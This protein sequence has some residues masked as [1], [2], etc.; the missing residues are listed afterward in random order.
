MN[1]G[2]INQGKLYPKSEL[3]RHN[4]FYESPYTEI[5]NSRPIE[6]Y[7]T[8]FEST[9]ENYGFII[10]NSFLPVFENTSKKYIPF[11][12]YFKAY[13]RKEKFIPQK[14][15]NAGII[16]LIV[17]LVLCIIYS[18]ATFFFYEIYVETGAPLFLVYIIVASLTY[19]PLANKIKSS[20]KLEN[21]ELL[22]NEEIRKPGLNETKVFLIVSMSLTGVA[23]ISSIII[24]IILF[25]R[26]DLYLGQ[27]IVSPISIIIAGIV[28]IIALAGIKSKT[29]MVKSFDFRTNRLYFVFQGIAYLKNQMY[30][31]RNT[32]IESSGSTFGDFS[33]G[34]IL[35]NN[36]SET[37]ITS[38]PLVLADVDKIE[39]KYMYSLNYQLY[40]E[41]RM[42]LL[43]DDF[44]K[45]IEN[46]LTSKVTPNNNIITFEEAK[47]F[48]LTPS[49][50][51]YRVFPPIIQSEQ[52]PS[53]KYDINYEQ[54]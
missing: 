30:A 54:R 33:E 44:K 7:G 14:K 19:I 50:I 40:D 34:N 37:K 20:G 11:R 24:V 12:G 21:R 4:Y 31:F 17:F 16:A 36:P 25:D 47:E 29:E 13:E 49:P 18:I 46:I 48:T 32:G 23:I 53:E 2:T 8:L 28:C 9:I 22:S 3:V 43:K 26:Y 51:N 1:M 15:S 45:E 38:Q 35:Q 5:E 6:V 52:M 10:E 41:T 39:I 27:Y 42:R